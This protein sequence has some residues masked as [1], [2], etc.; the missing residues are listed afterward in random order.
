M[1]GLILF[2][3]SG[4]VPNS[5]PQDDLDTAKMADIPGLIEGA[6]QN[7]GMGHSFLRHIERTRLLLFVVDITGFQVQ[8]QLRHY[9]GVISHEFSA[10]YVTPHASCDMRYFVPIPCVLGA[11]RCLQ[12]GGMANPQLSARAPY[13]DAVSAVRLLSQELELYVALVFCRCFFIYFPGG[14]GILMVPVF[15]GVKVFLVS[16][17][18]RWM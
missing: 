18:P 4:S 11:D 1:C 2:L 12:S 14:G 8:W 3:F 9:F 13:Q 16:R 5:R 15:L 6:S 17:G 10:P 7:Y